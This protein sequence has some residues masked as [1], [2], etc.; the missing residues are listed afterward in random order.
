MAADV[1]R[2]ADGL[3]L[4]LTGD[5]GCR[6]FADLEGQLEA[7]DLSAAR[8]V[9]IDAQALTTLD[10]SGAWALHQFIARARAR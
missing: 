1:Q 6:Q 7:I 5:W 9:R 4:T 10:L 8:Q 2:T 3:E